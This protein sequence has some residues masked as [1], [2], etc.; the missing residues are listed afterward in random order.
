MLGRCW[1]A[2][3]GGSRTG[4]WCWCVMAATP[5]A[6]S[7]GYFQNMSKPIV[8]VAKLRKDAALYQPAPPR[9][10]GQIGRPRI[11]GARLPSPRAALDDP[12]TQ[13]TTYL[14]T[15]S[16]GGTTTVEPASGLALWYHG[17]PPQP[18]HT[19]GR[20][21]IPGGAPRALCFAMHRHRG[22]TAAD[23]AAVSAAVA[24]RGDL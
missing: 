9:R 19:L 6:S 12:A 24:G 3:A 13:W 4:T 10:P 7:C 22:G 17:G 20:R 8:V 2:C 1:S 18:S 5:N 16:D 11:V 15:G 14:A 23:I 21:Q